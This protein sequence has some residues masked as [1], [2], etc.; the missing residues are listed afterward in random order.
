VELVHGDAEDYEGAAG[1][2]GSALGSLLAAGGADVVTC[3]AAL[4]F[5]RDIPGALTRWRA[6]LRPETGRCVALACHAPQP[7]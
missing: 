4:P 3:S 7:D 2:R 5:F 1:G 6:W